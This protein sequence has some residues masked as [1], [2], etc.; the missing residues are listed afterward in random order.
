MVAVTT[1]IEYAVLVGKNEDKIHEM[2]PLGDHTAESHVGLSIQA[3]LVL[4]HY[5]W[6]AA[7][8][9]PVFVY[10]V[11]GSDRSSLSPS[12]SLC[13]TVFSRDRGI[14]S[15]LVGRISPVMPREPRPGRN[16]AVERYEEQP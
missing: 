6:R 3:P 4:R 15:I 10:A 12:Y 1:Q 8:I 2:I 16:Q 11:A 9:P 13:S 7:D 5:F 14:S